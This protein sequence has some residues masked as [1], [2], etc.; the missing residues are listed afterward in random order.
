MVR[1]R[2]GERNCIFIAKRVLFSLVGFALFFKVFFMFFKVLDEVILL[3]KFKVIPEMV[4]LLMGEEAFLIDLIES[5]LFA[6]N[7]I[8]VI[9]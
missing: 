8:P 1:C 2:F 5:I 4:N 7:D 6:P 3:A 9:I